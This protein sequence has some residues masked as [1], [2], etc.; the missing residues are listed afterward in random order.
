MDMSILRAGEK[1][2]KNLNTGP[3]SCPVIRTLNHQKGNQKFSAFD[4]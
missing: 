3:Y 4:Y 2:R 1:K